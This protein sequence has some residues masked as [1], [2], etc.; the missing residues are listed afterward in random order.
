MFVLTTDSTVDMTREFMELRSIPFVP[1]IYISKNE[2]HFDDMTLESA[3]MIYEKM[4]N[5]EVITTSQP[6]E[7]QFID[8]WEPYIANN[9]DVLYIGFSSALSGTVNSARL[10][11]D[12]LLKKYL[13]RRIE[14]VD[15]LDASGGEGLLLRHVCD[16]MKEGHDLDESLRF[17]ENLKLRIHHWYTV[18]NLVYLKRSGRV[19]AASAF[20][21][22]ML[23][24]K[25][26][27]N[28]DNVGRLIPREKV[29]GRKTSIRSIFNHMV[30]SI[31]KDENEN[32]YI[33]ITNA[34]SLDDANMLKE[35]ILAKFSFIK[36]VQITSVGAVIGSHCGPGTLALFFVGALRVD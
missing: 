20:L 3:N 1:L 36:E 17:A 5:G 27:M 32:L 2:E 10:A 14:I 29:N 33:H 28:M 19:S 35:L 7:K 25:P 8:M 18:D 22:S 16:Y 21:G 26:V 30:D 13:G 31:S 12:E 4:R 11:K 9:I 34:D 24:I 15:S 23:R 6:S